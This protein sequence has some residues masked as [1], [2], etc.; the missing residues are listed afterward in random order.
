M[1]FIQTHRVRGVSPTGAARV[2][3]EGE[4]MKRK[5]KSLF[6]RAWRYMLAKQRWNTTLKIPYKNVSDGWLQGFQ[7][8]AHFAIREVRREVT[9]TLN[10]ELTPTERVNLI[11]G[12]CLGRS[13]GRFENATE[14]HWR[15][16]AIRL[17]R[18]HGIMHVDV[19]RGGQWINLISDGGDLVSHIIE[20]A[21][22]NAAILHL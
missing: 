6:A 18:L 12:Y 16:G 15:E 17:T 3:Q 7:A 1:V 2:S 10:S 22:I 20:V 19:K 14:P 21:G 8:G 5:D 13:N 11:A 9:R 4:A